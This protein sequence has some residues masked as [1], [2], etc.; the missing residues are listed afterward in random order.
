MSG[1]AMGR[2]RELRRRRGR[3]SG[4]VMVRIVA[5]GGRRG[6][7]EVVRGGGGGAEVAGGCVDADVGCVGG[8]GGGAYF[9]FG[10]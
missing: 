2:R 8:C 5:W 4:S 10:G 6:F 3:M 9:G 1:K 7:V